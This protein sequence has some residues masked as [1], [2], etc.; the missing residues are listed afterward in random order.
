MKKAEVKS[1]NRYLIAVNLFLIA[2]LAVVAVYAWFASNAVNGVN[3][4]D[5][6]VLADNT[7]EL[8]FDGESNWSETLNLADLKTGDGS[9]T[10]VLDTMKFIAVTGNGDGDFYIPTLEQ[11]QNYASVNTAPTGWKTAVANTDYLK[12]TVHMRSK[13]PLYVFLSSDSYARPSSYEV[14]GGACGNPSSYATGDDSFSKDCIVGALR[15]AGF[16]VGSDN[17]KNKKFVWITNPEFHLNNDVGSSTYSMDTNA[18]RGQY[19]AVTENFG[20]PGYPFQWNDPYEHKYYEY[21]ATSGATL[22]K[23]DKVIYKLSDSDYESVLQAPKNDTTLLA[24]LNGSKA[25]DGYFHSQADFVVWIEGC[26]TEARRALIDGKFNL[27]LIFDSFSAEEY[28][29]NATTPEDVMNGV[30]DDFD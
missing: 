25:A 18:S 13:D 1:K 8:S 14:T 10:S 7:L 4:N 23:E 11:K 19:S 15:V 16:Q 26:D 27:S 28:N 12:F 17:T 20:T 6:Q 5:I 29:T 3:T 30:G 9:T 2:I 21:N 24:T 22:K